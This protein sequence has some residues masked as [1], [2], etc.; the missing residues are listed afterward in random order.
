MRLIILIFLVYLSNQLFAQQVTGLVVDETTKIPIMNARVTTSSY[1]TFTTATGRF[2]LNNVHFGDTITVSHMG[3]ESYHF[4][5]SNSSKSDTMLILLKVSPIALQEIAIK[6]IRN[7]TQDSLNRR[8]EFASVFAYKAPKF[9]D[10]FITKSANTSAHYSPFQNSTSTLVSVNLLSVIGLLTKNKTPVSKLQKKLLKEEEYN[11]VDHVFSR[12]KVRSLTSLK[13]DSLQNFMTEYRP[14]I[15]EAKQ[16][17][18]YRLLLY[19]KKS[20]DEFTK[21]YKPENFPSLNK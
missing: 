6:G 7:Y 20:Y 4:R 9:K 12:E 21:T 3:Y 17:T 8:K 19:I 13:G 10:I 2:S 1:G 11:Y 14:S 15:E 5:H 16:M 18:D